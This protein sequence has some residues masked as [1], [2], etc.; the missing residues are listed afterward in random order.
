MGFAAQAQDFK[1][2]PAVF[3]DGSP[4]HLSQT[5]TAVIHFAYDGTDI[6]FT[7]TNGQATAIS[8]D[9]S[10]LAIGAFKALDINNALLVNDGVPLTEIYFE[11]GSLGAGIIYTYKGRSSQARCNLI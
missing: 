7:N 6:Q 3:S 2:K 5:M 4:D 1:C 10:I 9:P 8:L 11:K